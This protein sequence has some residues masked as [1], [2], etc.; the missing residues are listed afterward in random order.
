MNTIFVLQL[1][2]T[3]I[4]SIRFNEKFIW[5]NKKFKRPEWAG[6]ITGIV[7]RNMIKRI[8]GVVLPVATNAKK[9]PK[10]SFVI[11]L[12]ID[13]QSY[14]TE[15]DKGHVMALELGGPNARWNI[16]MQPS[17][18]QRFGHWRQFEKKIM[19]L[20]MKTYELENSLCADEAIH[21]TKPTNVLMIQYDLRYTLNKRLRSVSGRIFYGKKILSFYIPFKGKVIFNKMRS[22]ETDEEVFL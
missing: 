19:R 17:Q 4:D 5:S 8:T 1:L 21:M 3:F 20:A 6:E 15:N 9:C 12:P 7:Q 22:Y 18:W 2:F 13:I 10:R 11:P 14:T 16:V